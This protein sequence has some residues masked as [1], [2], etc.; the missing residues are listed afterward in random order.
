MRWQLRRQ[1]GCA[2]VRP[3]LWAR[4]RGRM[5]RAAQNASERGFVMATPAICL[6]C[7]LER[8]YPARRGDRLS[9]LRC[10][11]GGRLA[12]AGRTP[13]KAARNVLALIR[14]AA[15]PDATELQRQRFGT[16]SGCGAIR[17]SCEPPQRECCPD[18]SHGKPFGVCGSCGELLRG[19]DR[20]ATHRTL[21]QLQPKAI[22]SEQSARLIR[23]WRPVQW[24]GEFRCDFDI[25]KIGMIEG[26]C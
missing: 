23:T 10:R 7:G 4:Q 17:A 14:R 24:I 25:V 22:R 21:R 2:S 16:C 8:D 5:V 11:C 18:C 19:A 3:L 15:E 9:E 12:R 6:V 26:S 13:S 1:S 20:D